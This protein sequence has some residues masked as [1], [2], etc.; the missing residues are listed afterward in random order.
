[1]IIALSWIFLR[2]RLSGVQLS[3]VAVSLAGVLVILS[4]GSFE[5]LARSA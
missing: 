3:G 4:Q 1:M 2:D 5:V